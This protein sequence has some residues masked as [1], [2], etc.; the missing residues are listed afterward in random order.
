MYEYKATVVRWVDGDTVDLL[1]DL[2][3]QIFTKHRL[4]LANINT[5]ERGQPGWAEATARAAEL[6]PHGSTVLLRTEKAQYDKYGRYLGVLLIDAT[7]SVNSVL[8]GE[9]LAKHYGE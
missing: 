4:R 9:G 7:R 1:V 8:L 3:F 6:A 5:P 2:G